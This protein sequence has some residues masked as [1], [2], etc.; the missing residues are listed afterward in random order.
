MSGPFERLVVITEPN[1]APPRDITF[2]EYLAIDAVN[3]STLKHLRVSP[4]HYRHALTASC[5]DTGALKL[6]RAVHTAV[7]EPD[8]LLRDYVIWE[9]DRRAGKE[10]ERFK[11]LHWRS[12]ILKVDEFERACSIRDAVRAHPLVKPYLASG[13]AEKSITWTDFGTGL[14][15]KARLDWLGPDPEDPA[16]LVVGDLKT[17]RDA[18]DA[19]RFA[20][21]AWDMGYYGQLAH[22][23]NGVRTLTGKN[24]RAVIFAVENAP[25]FDVALWR[26]DGD[27]FL[28]AVAAV[29]ELLARLAEC[30]ATDSWPGRY[31]SEQLLAVPKWAVP[32]MD[33]VETVDPDWAEGA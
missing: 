10:W 29:R 11:E 15:C 27:A 13:E 16:A 33:D 22:Y 9:G 14:P 25:P 20:S 3:W 24:V 17:S 1:A 30:R 7:F 4:L 19:R 28:T 6:G 2:A 26:V 21:A 23:V 32:S 31:G 12:T 5:K 8:R 18:T